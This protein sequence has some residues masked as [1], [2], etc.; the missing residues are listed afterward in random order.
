MAGGE[1]G[2]TIS[3]LSD[4]GVSPGRRFQPIIIG[5]AVV[6]WALTHFANT[7]IPATHQVLHL[8]ITTARYTHSQYILKALTPWRASPLIAARGVMP[9]AVA[10]V[11]L[12]DLVRRPVSQLLCGRLERH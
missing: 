5:L 9:C 1:T 10:P 6:I 7:T 4:T 3:G 2:L 12:R 11:S 8:R